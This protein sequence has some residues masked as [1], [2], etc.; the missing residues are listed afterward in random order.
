MNDYQ[1]ET[2]SEYTNY[3]R[4]WVSSVHSDVSSPCDLFAGIYTGGRDSLLFPLNKRISGTFYVGKTKI[5]FFIPRCGWF[6]FQETCI[7]IIIIINFI[8]IIVSIG[9]SLASNYH[10]FILG[11]TTLCTSITTK[12]LRSTKSTGIHQWQHC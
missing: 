4:D 11:L 1:S 2:D 7:I 12:T 10:G 8:S 9:A 3:W 6:R 5:K